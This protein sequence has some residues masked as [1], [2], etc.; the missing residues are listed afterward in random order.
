MNLHPLARGAG[1]Q[2][3]YALRRAAAH[4]NPQRAANQLG[5]AELDPGTFV[6]VIPQHFPTG[7]LQLLVEPA[8]KRGLRFI[9]RLYLHQMNVEGSDALGPKDSPLVVVLLHRRGGDP[10]RTDA[11]GACLLYTS[12]SPR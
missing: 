2:F 6:T 4:G 12:P 8:R 10:G 3:D 9:L 1:L 7:L 11:V 5:V